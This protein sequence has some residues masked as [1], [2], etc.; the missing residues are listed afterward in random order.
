MVFLLT[1]IHIIWPRGVKTLAGETWC[2]IS[3]IASLYYSCPCR[4]QIEM[5]SK[6]S[7]CRMVQNAKQEVLHSW[8]EYNF[9]R[10]RFQD[11]TVYSL[12]VDGCT[13][14]QFD[15][16]MQHEGGEE[17]EEFLSGKL[18]SKTN[19]A[20]YSQIKAIITVLPHQRHDISNNQHLNCLLTT[21]ETSKVHI[22]DPLSGVPTDDRHFPL[23]NGQWCWLNNSNNK[24]RETYSNGKVG[25]DANRYSGLD[26]KLT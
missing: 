22:T 21:S 2:V 5:Q 4:N 16:E 7:F 24:T 6:G 11:T 18:L 12:Q 15:V 20:T 10:S 25:S 26:F 3:G 17:N 23:T 1:H 9:I 8:F 14:W 19:T 13:F